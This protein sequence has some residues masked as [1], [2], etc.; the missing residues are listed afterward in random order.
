M[1]LAA[2]RN[3]LLTISSRCGVHTYSAALPQQSGKPAHIALVVTSVPIATLGSI[4]SLIMEYAPLVPP[5]GL[6]DVNPFL[7]V[8]QE[9]MNQSVVVITKHTTM[10][11]QCNC[12]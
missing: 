12:A 3:P 11:G 6:V 8:A 2:R 5:T 7:Q 9:N 1:I 10:S 4:V